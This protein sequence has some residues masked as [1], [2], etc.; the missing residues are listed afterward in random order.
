MFVFIFFV[1]LYKM[2]LFIERD[3]REICINCKI[4][5]SRAPL[6]L[7]EQTFN[8]S[9][10]FR[11]NILAPIVKG[12]GKTTNFY[13]G[14]T[15]ELLAFRKTFFNLLPTTIG[16]I[17]A[18]NFIIQKAKIGNNTSIVFKNERIGYTQFLRLLCILKQELVQ[19]VIS[20]VK[21]GKNVVLSEADEIHRLEA[22]INQFVSLSQLF[23]KL[24][25]RFCTLFGSSVF[26][27]RSSP[28]EVEG[29]FTLQN[30]RFSNR[31]CHDAFPFF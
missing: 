10:Q 21:S 30:G 1:Q 24:P 17:L 3:S 26:Y 15:T 27:H 25:M 12:Y 7:L 11:T 20:A 8:L 29:I 19:V 14:I 6:F 16:D 23:H 18:A 13:C 5:K 4:A 2:V 28:L 22:N 9:H 31:S